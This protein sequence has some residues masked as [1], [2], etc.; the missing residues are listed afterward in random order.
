MNCLQ[1]AEINSLEIILNVIDFYVNF[2]CYEKS[3][4]VIAYYII[5]NWFYKNRNYEHV[6]ILEENFNSCR[7]NLYNDE[8]IL[9]RKFIF[10]GLSIE[11][12]LA[13]FLFYSRMGE[14]VYLV[15]SSLFTNK[16]SKI[17]DF[18]KKIKSKDPKE[19]LKYFEVIGIKNI[20]TQHLYT[21]LE[22][23]LQINKQ[24]SHYVYNFVVMDNNGVS[25]V[26]FPFTLLSFKQF[27]KRQTLD[28]NTSFLGK[29]YDMHQKEESDEILYYKNSIYD[30]ENM[31]F[32]DIFSFPIIFYK[33]RCNFESEGNISTSPDSLTITS[34]STL[35]L[36]TLSN[37]QM[38]L[39][40]NQ[41]D[42]LI[43]SSMSQDSSIITSPSTSLLDT[44][45]N[46]QMNL[47]LNQY[48]SL[49]ASPLSQDSSTITSLSTSLLD[50]LSN[51]QVNLSSP[52]MIDC[53]NN[54]NLNFD[55]VSRLNL[56]TSNLSQNCN[57]LFSKMG[58]I[59]TANS[60][61]QNLGN[62]S[63]DV[64]YSLLQQRNNNSQNNYEM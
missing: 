7:G 59:S 50:T 48:N 46:D 18:V 10:K 35:L 23:K 41:Y 4:T 36:D 43:A 52:S 63:T 21:Y 51:D 42:S 61:F 17:S 6:N 2:K 1:F 37:D 39:P 53:G 16:N 9:L 24:D 20:S 57:L 58:N 60:L 45:S 55:M 12:F 47:P 13:T 3:L 62:L 26:G 34:P 22:I 25:H 27:S 40:L 29:L 19:L 8:D 44:L 38:N 30:H 33:R 15:R 54:Q 14:T 56:V 11:E 49:I 64:D 28:G 32:K 5:N 31:Q